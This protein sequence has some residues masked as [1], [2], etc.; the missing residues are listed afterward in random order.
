MSLTLVSH[1]LCPYVQRVA[2]VLAEK[3]LPFTRVD[4][5][6]ADKPAWFLA[7]SP[8]GKTPML[9]VGDEALFES[10]AILEYLDETAPPRLHPDGALERARH[11]AWIEYGA[12]LLNDIGAFYNARDEQALEACAQT[13]RTR[14]AGLE[15]AL[16]DGPYFAGERFSLVDAA[17]APVFRYLD[18]FESLG[19][20][21][22]FAPESRLQA[23]R[24]ALAR[25]ASVAAAA[26]P[27]YPERLRAFLQRRPS[28]LAARMATAA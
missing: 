1:P 7:L 28:A 26:A 6:L 8:T 13:L 27:A 5:D 17:L 24:G 21:P 2:T 25:R 19:H 12:L 10:A 4:I 18:V 11:R 16:G 3:N 23:W 22:F 14:F 9:L 20:G 15:K